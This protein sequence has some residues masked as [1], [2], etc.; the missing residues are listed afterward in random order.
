VK[1]SLAAAFNPHFPTKR[2]SDGNPPILSIYCSGEAN[3]AILIKQNNK[4]IAES[5][6]VLAAKLLDAL[7]AKK[8]TSPPPASISAM[9]ALREVSPLILGNDLFLSA[10]SPSTA[11]PGLGSTASWSYSDLPSQSAAIALHRA[12]SMNTMG[13]PSLG[14]GFGMIPPPV[15]VLEPII[16]HSAPKVET[17]FSNMKIHSGTDSKASLLL[18]VIR[19][20]SHV[21]VEVKA[22][23]SIT[24]APQTATVVHSVSHHT[25][26]QADIVAFPPQAVRDS[27]FI[28]EPALAG[29]GVEL[30]LAEGE[31]KVVAPPLHVKKAQR[32]I[33]PNA[34][35]DIRIIVRN[36]KAMDEQRVSEG[37][38]MRPGAKMTV[39][40]K[41]A[42]SSALRN[43]NNNVSLALGLVRYGAHSNLP[44]I[45]TK[46]AVLNHA[47]VLRAPNGELFY[48]GSIPF[49]APKAAGK[50]IY[51]LYDQRTREISLETLGISSMFAVILL[52]SDIINNL[53]HVQDAFGENLP[54]KAISQL[55]SII[56]GV[57]ACSNDN[58]GAVQALNRCTHKLLDQIDSSYSVLDEA[59]SRKNADK[60]R[61]EEHHPES[62]RSR[63]AETTEAIDTEQ[64]EHPG[65][66]GNAE[67][68]SFWHS[69]RT[70]CKV[71]VEAYEALSALMTC[72]TPWY[73]L[74]EKL[75]NTVK[76]MCS[77]YCP[78]FKRF[79]PRPQDMTEMR[80]QALQFSPALPSPQPVSGA[81]LHALD[82]QL[83]LALPS[84]FPDYDYAAVRER[85]REKLQRALA[86][87][88]A[89]PPG[90]GLV[91]Y[92]S[93]ANNFGTQSADMDMCL[94]F[95]GQP[96]G[97]L[98]LTEEDKAVLINRIGDTLN[99]LGMSEVR[100]RPTARI[101]IVQY[102]DPL[103]GLE[104]DVSL[105]NPLAL[106]NTRLLRIYSEIDPRVRSLAFLVKYWAKA[107]HI[108]SPSDGTLS[109]YGFI[110]TILHFL[111]TRPVPLLPSLQDLPPDWKGERAGG[112]RPEVWEC[113]AADSFN[114]RCN[115]YFLSPTPVQMEILRRHA[116]KNEE[117]LAQL[118][119]SYFQ[120]YAWSFDYRHQVVSVRSSL[121][122][123]LQKLD[124]Y[125][126]AA[127]PVSDNLSIEDPFEIWYDVGHVLKAPQMFYLRKEFLRAYTICTRLGFEG[128]AVHEAEGM[129]EI[130]PKRFLDIL[131]EPSEAPVFHRPRAGTMH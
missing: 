88:G 35:A 69:Y 101:P 41:I 51:R 108:N 95:S 55:T 79:F 103:T 44:A 82:Q 13:S 81:L 50:F 90:A 64:V 96:Q 120:H 2:S 25:P 130:H 22:V 63:Y 30:V 37:F 77:L 94:V 42:A 113:N 31:N 67:D 123:V 131:C 73:L 118:L 124:K 125:E 52:E 34:G 27:Q 1:K 19:S 129:V 112:A 100:S 14:M 104:G 59:Q 126:R 93:S 39:Q 17:L 114:R 111:Q 46:T 6:N 9:P 16:P 53:Q 60:R 86:T 107:R 33:N 78:V 8:Q 83:V 116:S 47:T 56:R 92:G 102:T 36:P 26:C 91:L 65:A 45:V 71:H 28:S 43:S 5:P 97:C 119:V 106:A 66:A 117:S 58:Y 84:L 105:H 24:A 54:L 11:P 121:N 61:A 21:E 15:P 4:A 68:E 18:S 48:T 87:A 23:P 89:L 62:S 74:K 40:W 109:S 122:P 20:K 57:K 85:A 80:Y 70:V 3:W 10:S 12:H 49:F 29:T 72:K 128:G 110:L 75:K 98:D 32:W 76:F 115:V 127:W 7:R 38:Y 99:R